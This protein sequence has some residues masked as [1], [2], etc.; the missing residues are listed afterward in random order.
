LLDII[1]IKVN[2]EKQ[3]SFTQFLVKSF[4]QVIQRESE[5]NA[6]TS[7]QGDI[8]QTTFKGFNANMLRQSASGSSY[9]MRLIQ[10]SR[11]LGK[12]KRIPTFVRVINKDD[13]SFSSSSKYGANL[14]LLREQNFKP[15]M[16]QGGSM[17]G[18]GLSSEEVQVSNF[19]ILKSDLN[20]IKT[21]KQES[22]NFVI[23]DMKSVI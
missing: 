17:K 1:K 16:V 4:N 20:H 22:E 6:Q 10:E 13:N 19:L 2:F 5:I 23:N 15:E 18:I 12:K 7:A 3:M 21:L 14:R 9:G 8:F 11:I